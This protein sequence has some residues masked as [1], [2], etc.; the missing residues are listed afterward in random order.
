MIL[1][2]D[3]TANLPKELYTK[4]NIKM[5]PLQV[6]LDGEVYDDLSDQLPNKEF[7]DKMRNGTAPK[8][9]Q[10][11]AETA[12][13][14]FE[15]LLN[16]GED[17]IHISFSSAL[18][19]NTDTIIRIANELNETHKNKVYV[20]NSL[21]ASVGEGI[22]VLKARELIDQNKKPQ[23]IVDELNSFKHNVCAYFTVD[24]LKYLVRGGR[25]S[26]FSGVIGSILNIKPVL[27]VDE[28]GRLVSFKKVMSRKKSIAELANICC[29][30][31]LDNKYLFIGHGDCIDDANALADMVEAKLGVRPTIVDITQ[32]ICSHSGPGTLAIF[33]VS[34]AGK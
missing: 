26:K 5:I 13:A 1:S 19:G 7:H 30:K 14:Y 8:T 11:N 28:E 33:F 32:V 20:I 31:I 4:H 18:S 27:R 21:Q 15:L 3:S 23:E 25:V 9:A 6:I 17:V 34:K 2:T 10:I 22:I 16:T 29:E 24:Q 12:K